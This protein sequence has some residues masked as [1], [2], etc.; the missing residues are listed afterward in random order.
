MWIQLSVCGKI[1]Q[2]LITV[3]IQLEWT[4]EKN[5][6]TLQYRF[7]ADEYKYMAHFCL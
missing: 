2:S 5:S 7:N 3:T 4:P 1:W 6:Q